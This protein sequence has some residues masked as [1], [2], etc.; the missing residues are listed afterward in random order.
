MNELNNLLAL[1]GCTPVSNPIPGKELLKLPRQFTELD[2]N[3]NLE[4]SHTFTERT[5]S[6]TQQQHDSRLLVA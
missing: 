4:V 5:L 3:R 1:P 6:A 2:A